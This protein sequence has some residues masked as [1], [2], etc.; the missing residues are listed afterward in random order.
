[1][2]LAY[3]DRYIDC[4]FAH[5]VAREPAGQVLAVV[6][7][8]NNV[9]EHFFAIAKQ[10]L[11]Q[12]LGP[13]HLGRDMEDQ[14]ARRALP[15]NLLC[16][17]YVQIVCGTLDRLPQAFAAL[18]RHSIRASTPLQRNNK[19]APLRKRIRAW[20]VT[21]GEKSPTNQRQ[22]DDSRTDPSATDS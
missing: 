14:Q 22:P 19:D 11:R 10:Q 13:A 18:D 9:A 2:V 8:P 6:G 12:R 16:P 4:L 1:M 5:P 15:A 17:H 7:R 3:L 21:D 20:A